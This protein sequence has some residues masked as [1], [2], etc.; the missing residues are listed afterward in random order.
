MSRKVI[1]TLAGVAAVFGA[2]S[3]APASAEQLLRLHTTSPTVVAAAPSPSVGVLAGNIATMFRPQSEASGT[4]ATTLQRGPVLK[5]IKLSFDCVVD[6][7]PVEFP[8]DIRISNPYSFATA[9]VQV[10]YAAPGGNTGVVM[11]P[12]LAP[13]QGIFVSN[14]VPGGGIVGMACTAQQL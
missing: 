3:V 13:G 10:A 4:A 14:A 6:G 12:A 2:L 9:S 7:T 8:N 1:T 5:P 11:L